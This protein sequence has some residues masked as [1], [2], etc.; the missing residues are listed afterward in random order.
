MAD[1]PELNLETSLTE[2]EA[3]V[4]RLEVGDLALEDALVAFERGVA[5]VR[6]LH[7]ILDRAEQRVEV[8]T[9]DTNGALRLAPLAGEK[10]DS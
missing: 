10:G 7:S 2:L 4:Q 3:I 9:R 6:Q 1:Q 8:L 5:L